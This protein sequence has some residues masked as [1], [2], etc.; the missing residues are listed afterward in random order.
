M[1]VENS[2][3]L[4]IQEKVTEALEKI[5]RLEKEEIYAY[6]F[7][8]DYEDG[9]NE[10]W[11]VLVFS[12][13]TIEHY[14]KKIPEKCDG[15]DSRSLLGFL[16]SI[17]EEGAESVFD[18][19][20]PD[21]LD[22]KWNYTY[23][24]QNSILEVGTKEDTTGRELVEKWTRALGLY[25]TEDE[26]AKNMEACLERGKKIREHFVE[27]LVGVVRQMH[28]HHELSV[29]VIVHNFEYHKQV[30]KQNLEANGQNLSREFVEWIERKW[31]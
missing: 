2:L 8:Y 26:L 4:Y 15:Q 25:F 30:A 22:V 24:L 16:S 29:P 12:Y 17:D 23:W 21:E 19:L 31:A 18:L 13:N 3:A 7:L 28:K 27:V 20:K 10:N 14:S 11:P 6:S 9:D 1:S 5:V